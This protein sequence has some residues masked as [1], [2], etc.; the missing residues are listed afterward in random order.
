MSEALVKLSDVDTDAMV[1]WSEEKKKDFVNT[2]DGRIRA[3]QAILLFTAD[4]I[5]SL[6]I[7]KQIV[8]RGTATKNAVIDTYNLF[9][10][11]S[12]YC[13]RTIGGRERAELYEIAK[14]RASELMKNLPPLKKIVSVIDP[15]TS[16]NIIE[17]EKLEKQGQKWV[18]KLHEVSADID[19]DDLD[20]T[21]TIAAMRKMVNQRE[22]SRRNYVRKLDEIASE[23]SEL[24]R[25]ISKKLYKGVPGLAEAAVKAVNDC[26]EQALGFDQLKRRVSEKVMFGD[27]DAA[28]DILKRFEHDETALS[29][30][31][32]AQFDA[33]VQ[34]LNLKSAPKKK[35]TAKKKANGKTK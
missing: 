13:H 22:K 1:E 8:G 15:E 4:E 7:G 11:S 30:D 29:D 25:K 17:K 23:V 24:D 18:D 9:D 12:G 32:A 33:A 14:G 5:F 26:R 3:A 20:Q 6:A 35:L 21:M 16:K 10:R 27:S 31:V 2:F 28:V 34:K 19:L